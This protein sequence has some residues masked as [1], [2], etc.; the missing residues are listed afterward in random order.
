MKKVKKKIRRLSRRERKALYQVSSN[1][2]VGWDYPAYLRGSWRDK[3]E[4]TDPI[5]FERGK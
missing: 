3:Y 1:A 5:K 4:P 2:G